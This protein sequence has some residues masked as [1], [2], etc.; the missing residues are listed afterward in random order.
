MHKPWPTGLCTRVKID[1]RLKY[2]NP[3][4]TVGHR[5]LKG[6]QGEQP[7]LITDQVGGY[8]EPSVKRRRQEEAQ[9]DVPFQ[10]RR[11]VIQD[12]R[13]NEVAIDAIVDE[14]SDVG[15][16]SIL[17]IESRDLTTKRR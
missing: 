7:L 17:Q 12:V 14:A 4:S 5:T 11:S 13:R 9:D 10:I 2:N 16:E 1:W 6:T 8:E 3:S 15:E